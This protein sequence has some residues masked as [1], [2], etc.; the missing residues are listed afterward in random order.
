MTTNYDDLVERALASA[1]E[2]FDVVWYEA[3][4]GPC[5][6]PLPAPRARRRGRSDRAPEQVHAASTR[7][8]DR[9]PQAAR[10]DRPRRRRTAT[11]T[12]SPRTT[13]STT[14]R[15][16]TSASRFPFTL[17]RA[18]GREPLPLPRLLDARLEPA[19]HPATG[20]GASSGSTVKSWAVQR[21]P[22]NDRGRA[23][24][25]GSALARPRRRRPRCTSPLRRRT[26]RGSSASSLRPTA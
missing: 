11:A 25:R 14:S 8:A 23:R 4:R 5:A 12:S 19:R 16:A 6:G 22:P 9:D 20:S 2:P 13:T 24:G 21:E 7:G 3:K 1:G 18:H 26:S 15:A 17:A 10:R